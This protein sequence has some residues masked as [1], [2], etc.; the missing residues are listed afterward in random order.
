MESNHSRIYTLIRQPSA[1]IFFV[2]VMLIVF[3]QLANP[4]FLSPV[5]ISTMLRALSYTGIIA[6]GMAL[7]LISG[8]IDLSVG[9]TAALASVI[10]G[11]AIRDYSVDLIPAILL[12]LIAG[13]VV[14]LINS[15]I[16]LKL[17]VTPFIATISMMFVIRGV[18]NWISNGYNVYPLSDTV[19]GLGQTR[20]LGV[21]WAFVFFIFC[22]ITAHLILQYT[23]LGLFI[24]AVGS[25]REVAK[26]TEVDVD[27]TN[28]IVLIIVSVLAAA[29]GIF[30][31]FIINAG[32]PTVG[33]GWEFTAITACAIGGVSLFGYHGTIFGMFCGLA[34]VQIIQNGLVM[35]GF[36]PYLQ[37]VA[38][39]AILLTAMVIDVRRRT[40]LDLDRI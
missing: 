10:F 3:F 15:F 11:T 28:G 21:S 40:Y 31:S 23:L 5:N 32:S 16:I 35:V 39:G 30:I 37:G 25:D 34:V 36:S 22:A 24:R 27:K 14:G 8:I 1:G 7:C 17:K 4:V 29:S 9:S 13:L 6:V 2:L 38:V 33:A 19:L 12:G 26:C 20:A 18:A